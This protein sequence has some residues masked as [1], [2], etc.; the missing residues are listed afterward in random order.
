M[1]NMITVIKCCPGREAVVE[2]I[3]NTLSSLQQ[4]VECDTIQAVY[5]YDDPIAVICD[6]NGKVVG[7]P[8]NRALLDETETEVMDL[9]VGTFLIVGVNFDEGEFVSLTDEL[10]ETYLRKFRHPDVFVQN[11]SGL[12]ISH[13]TPD[14]CILIF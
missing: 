8:L 1:S 7:K 5:P 13:L 4:A 14:G 12:T 2:Q 11:G 6:D 3:E 9:L 10:Q